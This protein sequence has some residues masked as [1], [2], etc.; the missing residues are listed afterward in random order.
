MAGSGRAQERLE[1]IQSV[2]PILSALRTVSQASMQNA[3]RRLQGASRYGQDL[4]EMASWLPEEDQGDEP[5]EE[6]A[7]RTLVIVLGSDRGLVGTF[8]NDAVDALVGKLAALGE[9]GDEV[10]TWALGQRLKA[11]LAREEIA[12]DREERFAPGSVP[13]YQRAYDLA[14]LI[15][16]R[17]QEGGVDRVLVVFNRLVRADRARPVIEQL[18]PVAL[19]RYQGGGD[20][21][22]WPPPILDTDPEGLRARIERQALEVNLYRLLLTSSAAEHATRFHLLEDA[23]QNMDRLTEEL[24]MEVQ[25]M[26]QQAI[27]TEM[28]DLITAA[29]LIK[30]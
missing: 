18:L 21:P 6:A 15:Q 26:R 28:M 13:G 20:A 2:E 10:E 5:V 24:E 4:V 7:A 11:P 25:L 23:A 27:T 30:S 9:Q 29:G 8:N 19:A 3:R 17:V 14:G 16:E 12:P 1:N 22:D